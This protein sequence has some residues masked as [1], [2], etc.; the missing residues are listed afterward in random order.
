MVTVTFSNFFDKSVDLFWYDFDGNK[1]FFDH[2]HAGESKEV[3]TYVTH[4]WS[5][6][7]ADH[8]HTEIAIMDKLVWIPG[9]WN[10]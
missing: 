8:D 1:V 3:Q 4:P 9:N 6:E 2:I 10:D 7:P 5:A